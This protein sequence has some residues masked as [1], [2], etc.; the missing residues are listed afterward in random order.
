MTNEDKLRD[1]LKRVTAELRDTRQLLHEIEEKQCEPL[2]IVGMA[3]RFPG[4][5]RSPED[6]W[7]LV[8]AGSNA[9]AGLPTDRGW[10]TQALYDPDPDAV[11][12]SY[13]N[14][15]GFLYDAADFDAEF[16]EISPH[17]ALAMDPQQRL[18]L[19][20]TWETFE[21]AGIAP[22]SL[23]GSQ[24]GV[25]V[26]AVAPDY[27]PR[28]HETPE[29]PQSLGG[30][31]LTG[32]TGSVISGRLAYTF[33]LEG[34]TVTVDTA[35]SSSLV[36]LHLAAQALRQGECELALS[37]GIT[38]MSTPNVFIDFSRLRGLAL[39]GRC[40]SFAAA[41]DGMGPSE[42]VG[43]VLLERLSDA[44]RNGHQILAIIAGSAI[45][46]DGA[47]NGLTAPNG[48]SQQRVIRQAL[49]NARLTPADV[50]AVEAHGTGTKLGDPIEAQ[51][52]LATYGQ[53]RPDDQ[54][55]WLGS[56]K[57]NIGHTQAAAGVGGV[58]KMIM[59]MRHGILP[60]TLHIDEPSPY[61]DWTTGSVSLLT[62]AMPW[63]ETG[64]PRRAGVSSFGISG[65]NA[66][67]ILEQ[68][69]KSEATQDQAQPPR[70]A[71]LWLPWVISARSET[72][73]RA[74]AKQLHAFL[75]ARPDLSLSD[76]GY[77]LATTRSTFEHRAAV[78]AGDY[79]GF[80][81]CLTALTAGE[82][83]MYVAQGCTHHTGKMAFLFTGGGS[84]Y[85]GMGRDL[86]QTYPVFTQA[87]DEVCTHLDT[88]LE[89]PIRAVM[90]ALEGSADAK[91]LDQ[92]AFMQSALF[93]LEVALFRLLTHWGLV[94][95]FLIGHSLG[96]LT[97]AHVAG[98]LSLSDA[99]K[100]V[101]TRGR[102]MQTR[103]S[104]G[105]MLSLQ[106][107]ADEVQEQLSGCEQQVSIAAI[108]G[109]ILTVI[110]GDE[111][112]V[113]RVANKFENRGRKTKRLKIS[114]AS[115]SPHMD[116]ILA[117]FRQIAE[118]LTFT[119]PMLP[120]ISNVTGERVVGDLMCSSEYW[121]LHVRQAV[122]FFDGIRSLEKA[123]VTTYIE[124][125]PDG[126]L[127]AMA[128]D[129]LT[130]EV[131]HLPVLV[132][133]LRRGQPE[134][135][136]LQIALAHAHVQGATLNWHT[137]FPDAQRVDLP[138][139]PFQRQRYWLEAPVMVGNS[140]G[141]W[142]RVS[143]W[144]YRV[145][146][147]LL[148]DASKGHSY[149]VA[150]D[151]ASGTWLVVVPGREGDKS[152]AEVALE[153]GRALEDCGVRVVQ[154]TLS[155]GDADRGL[156]AER[157]KAR[158]D[159]TLASG[160]LSLLALDEEPHPVHSVIS[161]GMAST[162]ALV[163]AL[164][165]AGVEAP[166]WLVTQ[167][168][169]SVGGSDRLRS[170]M[171][172]L[173]WGLG[174]VV[175]L[176]HPQRWGGLVDLP[177]TPQIDGTIYSHLVSLLGGSTHKNGSAYEDQVALRSAGLFARRLVRAKLSRTTNDQD[178]KPQGTVLITG[179]TGALGTHVARWLAHNGAEHLVL[180]SRGGAATPGAASLV[181]ELTAL[182]TRITVASCDVA[183]R[184]ALSALLRQLEDEGC[185][186]RT[187]IHAAGVGKFVPLAETT[188]AEFAYVVSAKVAGAQNLNELLGQ[189]SLDAFVLFSSGAGVWG[190]GN[191]GAYAAGNAFLDALAKQYRDS[192]RP[193]TAVAWG[194]WDGGGM[195]DDAIG[196]QLH[197]R[198]VLL[199]APHLALMAL[200][201]AHSHDETSVVVAN[202]DWKR[203][204]PAFTAA[205]PSR[206]FLE[207]PEVRRI[208][209]ANAGVSK[210]PSDK[211]QS[212]AQRIASF[213]EAERNRTI[214]ELVRT[215]LASVLGY[216]TSST[217]DINREFMAL[218]FDSLSAMQ[219]RNSLNTT[220]GLSLPATLIFD[221]P[222]PVALVGYL[223]TQL[224]PQQD[225]A[226]QS[227]LMD[228]D[229][230]E[231]VLSTNVLTEHERTKIAVRLESLLWKWNTPLNTTEA[232]LAINDA[233]QAVTDDELFEALD[234]E[235]ESPSYSN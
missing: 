192:G 55:L 139:Y 31:L 58:I 108:N 117:Q 221:Y 232:N 175:G 131:D 226:S 138:T 101:V 151:T 129:C 199:M 25:F 39:D 223:R 209:T 73:L 156:L 160:I 234:D 159:R 54:P 169:V 48:L 185:G 233:L 115:H 214:V 182:G 47:S 155:A 225:T 166:L 227:I 202:I 84:Q 109:P 171:Q 150:G 11:G 66:H 22:A 176:E 64:H 190:G 46:Q 203:F 188:L 67:V 212:L 35:C 91:L 213:T 106:A 89:R 194:Y 103:P 79:E 191:L 235:L 87:L 2:V 13:T 16:F 34:P 179:G 174:R 114:H 216:T 82:M 18:L 14:S 154:M 152:L 99:A 88:H 23:R 162:L 70:A 186:I 71:G 42:G 21:Q 116:E 74:Q 105:A 40:K 97:A 57:S 92:I 126:V 81:R 183:D 197:R 110:A 148:A 172:A 211:S 6:L 178:W 132:P 153:C 161:N 142:S 121:V 164:G 94:P 201:Y 112:A 10:D 149:E 140:E 41:A 204:L 15:G 181:A 32:T 69:P 100:L 165:D 45:N 208:L 83:S 4:G 145:D 163:Q 8:S 43:L 124:L 118:G 72:A 219:L 200:G 44:R 147:K 85:L 143:D 122:R 130:E 75:T 104:G 210:G 76:I 36:A 27:G 217:I 218:G 56:L 78:V 93:A 167:G 196:E 77:S 170:P 30:Y 230:I 133:V 98:V 215:T 123:G 59:A 49:A 9:I 141:S 68:A 7:S 127:T 173:I 96:E 224:F 158:I 90:W 111:D 19:E 60:K 180:T 220:T 206:L 20:T 80:E 17:E 1:Y 157:V 24:T 193:A 62:Q 177:V 12:K 189:S 61:I 128:Q 52:I 207:M 119:A 5:V 146:W 229:K 50:D 28:L 125:G 228:L 51:A 136:A 205:R 26:G 120:I 231:A 184:S 33:G 222:T 135:H 168:A 195:G 86:Y 95:D 63:K 38:V 187:V 134:A 144:Y 107:S 53:N 113:L 3:C 29:D 37:G 198:G 65:T 102:L 137:I